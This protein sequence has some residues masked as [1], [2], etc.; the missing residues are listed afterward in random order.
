MVMVNKKANI[1]QTS[2]LQESQIRCPPSQ[3]AHSY[4]PLHY[5]GCIKI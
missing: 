5:H 2:V 4:F 3:P 1:W